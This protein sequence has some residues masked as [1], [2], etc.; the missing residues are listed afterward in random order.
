MH[1]SLGRLS[2]LFIL[3]A[4]AGSALSAPKRAVRLGLVFDGPAPLNSRLETELRREV[5]VLLS[6][7]ADVRLDA[8]DSLQGDWTLATVKK[9]LDRVFAEKSVT[10]VVAFGVAASNELR[11][12][13]S[14]PK[15]AFAPFLFD[16]SAQKPGKPKNLGVLYGVAGMKQDLKAFRRLIGDKPMT[17]VLDGFYWSTVPE[18]RKGFETFAAAEKLR[19]AFASPEQMPPSPEAVYLGLNPRS[20]MT[21]AIAKLN[22]A[23]VPTFSFWGK[24]AIDLGVLA[25]LGAE[26][27]VNRLTRLSK[28]LASHIHR[29][30]NGESPSSLPSEWSSDARLLINMPTASK[31]DFHPNW[32]VLRDAEAVGEAEGRSARLTFDGAI[33]AAVDANLE[34]AAKRYAT[35]V[36]AEDVGI[37]RSRLL[38]SLDLTLAGRIIDAERATASFGL[39]PERSI[40]ASATLRQS[41]FNEKAWAALSIQGDKRKIAEL[42]RDGT[43][44]DIIFQSSKTYVNVL[45]AQRMVTIQEADLASSRTNL[46]LATDRRTAGSANLIDVYRW[47]SEAA[48]SERMLIKAQAARQMAQVSLNQLLHRPLADTAALE[49][50]SFEDPRFLY[51]DTK[52]QTY[53]S[54]P[55]DYRVFS[56]FMV[57]E[58][59]TY[60]PEVQAME[61]VVSAQQTNLTSARREAWLPTF[62]LRADIS[63]RLAESGAGS[64]P[65]VIALPNL[66]VVTLPKGSNTNWSVGAEIALPIFEGWRIEGQKEQESARLSQVKAERSRVR[67]QADAQVRQLLEQVRASH[68][69][70][71]LARKS[72]ESARKSYDLVRDAYRRGGVQ[73]TTLVESQTAATSADQA[74]AVA[75]YDFLVDLMS[76]QRATARF[77]LLLTQEEKKESLERLRSYFD[78]RRKEPNAK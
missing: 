23:K 70:I 75:A 56:D 48:R 1:S 54:N 32:E 69:A 31:I 4:A 47:E 13:A 40:T 62:G 27:E 15:A 11:Q 59:L 78:K 71:A 28:K 72:S 68:S 25:A 20:D 12:R 8:R 44:L 14:V 38:P 52:A 73:M 43:R 29:A 39:E 35:D 18:L 9:N 7:E 10:L 53:F 60:L 46:K 16:E 17:V 41:I 67:E 36:Q 65:T 34:L 58:A 42:Q 76:L 49:D 24:D 55:W 64:G 50:L 2:A 61:S 57:Q 77:D 26:S 3:F 19:L 37:A 51:R 66:P 6:E 33:K 5:G 22:A 30:L 63:Q 45:K 21:G 74:A